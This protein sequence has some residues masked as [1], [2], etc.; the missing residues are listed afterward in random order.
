MTAAPRSGAAPNASRTTTWRRRPRTRRSRPRTHS[1]ARHARIESG[2]TGPRA[3]RR[4][5]A[6]ERPESSTVPARSTTGVADS[7]RP[8]STRWRMRR[9][10]V[11]CTRRRATRSQEVERGACRRNSRDAE[12]REKHEAV[13]EREHSGGRLPIRS[14]RDGDIDVQDQRRERDGDDVARGYDDCSGGRSQA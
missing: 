11:L 3:G 10:G 14:V 6:A 2:Q 5:S 13:A 8:M 4:A 1:G 12:Y 9:R 7:H